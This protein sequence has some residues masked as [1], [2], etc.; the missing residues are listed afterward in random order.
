MILCVFAVLALK[1]CTETVF[2]KQRCVL[3]TV[4]RAFLDLHNALAREPR[5][6]LAF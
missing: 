4:P 2:F 3:L 5:C 6:A 1:G